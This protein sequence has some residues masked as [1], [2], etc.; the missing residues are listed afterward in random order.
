MSVRVN[1]EQF[2]SRLQ[3]VSSGLS[4][5]EFLEQS[6][7]FVFQNGKVRTF[8]DETMCVAPSKLGK[9]FTGAVHAHPL[10]E[11]LSKLTEEE[12]DLIPGDGE[13]VV[14]GTRRKAGIRMEHE[15]FL[16]YSE[17]ETP[18]EWLPLPEGF[19]DGLAM[20]LGCCAGKD[21]SNFSLTCVHLTPKFV[22]ACDNTQITRYRMKLKL[23]GD[24]L[25]KH[26]AVKEVA[27]LGMTEYAETDGWLHFRNPLKLVVSCR[28]YLEQFPELTEF[29]NVKGTPTSLPGGLAEEV[30][31]ADVFA[32]DSPDKRITVELLPGK[33]RV[34]GAGAAGWFTATKE[35]NYKGEPLSFMVSPKV[36]IEL[37]GKHNECEVAPN[38]LKVNGEK[39]SYASLLFVPPKNGENPSHGPFK[40]DEAD[41]EQGD[42]DE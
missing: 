22:E 19:D 8:N 23:K 32:K 28:R 27:T 17:V 7:T 20:V 3:S 12:V 18:E 30:D 14:K 26:S 31:K 4:D 16:P 41:E 21:D 40:R 1:R 15:I 35:L 37:C 25:V 34:K 33:M 36:L 39:F 42:S 24:F 10:L 29:F 38:R 11:I 9:E 5:R 13:L 2:L 6:S